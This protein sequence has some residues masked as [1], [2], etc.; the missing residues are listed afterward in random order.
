M[1]IMGSV[2]GCYVRTVIEGGQAAQ[3]ER[4]Q[5]GD[6]ITKVGRRTVYKGTSLKGVL[7]LIKM[8]KAKNSQFV[9]GFRK[10]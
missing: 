1:T 3:D 5:V 7:G 4:V 2:F 10:P 6:I 8:E 9:V